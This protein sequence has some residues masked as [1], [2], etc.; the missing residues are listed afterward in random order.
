M[1]FF[2]VE[3]DYSREFKMQIDLKVYNSSAIYNLIDPNFLIFK[4]FN[5]DIQSKTTNIKYFEL[6]R[7]LKYKNEK[8][9]DQNLIDYMMKNGF[10]Y[11][12]TECKS[13]KIHFY[14]IS[15]EQIPKNTSVFSMAKGSN[16][17]TF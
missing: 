17:I 5:N 13:L 9:F 4:V 14:E 2:T 8:N 11:F 16:D 6:Y 1:F 3:E 7:Y 12:P 10:V 15:S